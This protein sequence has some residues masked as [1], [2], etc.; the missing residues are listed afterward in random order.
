MGR[1]RLLLAVVSLILAAVVVVPASASRKVVYWGRF[2]TPA[3]M[4]WIN[5]TVIPQ[6]KRELDIDLEFRSVTADEFVTALVGGAGPDVYTKAGEDLSL[7]LTPFLAKWADRQKLHPTLL[8]FCRYYVNGKLWQI[9]QYVD[10]RGIAYNKE[11]FYEA[12]LPPQAPTVWDSFLDYAKRMTAKDSAGE[13]TRVG[14]RAN[15]GA[16]GMTGSDLGVYI[17]LGGGEVVSRDYRESKLDNPGTR[18][19]LQYLIDVYDAMTING[20][21]VPNAW[22]FDNRVAMMNGH[23]G[24]PASYYQS[25][26]NGDIGAS[27]FPSAEPGIRPMTSIFVDGLSI[28]PGA[29]DVNAAWDFITF[30]CRPE[31]QLR[32]A[33]LQGRIAA[34]AD[35]VRLLSPEQ[36]RLMRPWYDLVDYGPTW[37]SFWIHGRDEVS[38]EVLKILRREQG[39]EAGIA[40]MVTLHKAALDALWRQ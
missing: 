4:E 30:M 8:E 33:E 36:A 18:R 35:T 24:T 12:G 15:L 37:N 10:V 5:D 38:A 11:L 28:V 14:F 22:F 39:V 40:N 17:L 1:R 25:N 31:I 23:P 6:V 2:L 27:P 32:F 3:S 13:F 26:P 34:R 29:R 7:D 16:G 9:P 20:S 21:V 19:A